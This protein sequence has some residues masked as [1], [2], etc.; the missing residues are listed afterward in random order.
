MPSQVRPQLIRPAA[1]ENDR[2]LGRHSPLLGWEAAGPARWPGPQA[3]GS[4]GRSHGGPC[5]PF[6]DYP[7]VNTLAHSSSEACCRDIHVRKY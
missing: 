7:A 3:G 5:V 6:T 4:D 2:V 1:E